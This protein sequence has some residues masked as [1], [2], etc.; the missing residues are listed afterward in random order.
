MVLGEEDALAGTLLGRLD[1]R[2]LES[3]RNFGQPS[4]ATGRVL[5]AGTVAEVGTAT[6]LRAIRTS[7]ASGQVRDVGEGAMQTTVPGGRRLAIALVAR[8]SG[9]ETKSQ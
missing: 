2:L 4:R 5:H 6:A 9:N 1:R 8:R 7:G 3:G